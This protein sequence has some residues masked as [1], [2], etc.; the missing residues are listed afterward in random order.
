MTSPWLVVGLGNPGSGYAATRHNVGYMVADVLAARLGGRWKKHKS[1][2]ADAVEGHLA[3]ERIVLGRSRSYMNESGGPVSALLKFYDVEPDHL[4]V[5]HDELD[6]DF[7]TLRIKSGGGDNGHNGLK[8]I[9]QSIDTGDF[10]R[11]RVGIGRPQGSQ[12]VHDFVL[13]G[14]SSTERKELAVQLED[15][16]DSVESLMTAGLARTQSAF[17]S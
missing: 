1:G 14:Y 5:I 6:I 16:A 10:Y 15:A 12:S 11:V 9:R 3:G 7:G 2:R 17:N 13:K 8:S 4:V